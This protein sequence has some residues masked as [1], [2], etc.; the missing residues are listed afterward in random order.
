M[1]IL[2]VIV[3]ASPDLGQSFAGW[4]GDASGT[5]NPLPLLMNQSKTIYANFTHKP[6]LSAGASFEGLK[7]EGFQMSLTGDF[8]ARYQLE[9][10]SNLVNWVPL[11]VLTNSYG[12]SQFLDPAAS[13]LNR[14]F[15]RFLLLP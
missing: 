4:S 10:S 11:A 1:L 12:T 5:Q 14:R 7:P 6:V 15:Y 8:G 3:T 9:T 13:T 2:C